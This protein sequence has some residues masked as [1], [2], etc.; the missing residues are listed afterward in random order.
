MPICP[1]CAYP[2]ADGVVRCPECGTAIE[3]AA[4]PGLSS[5]GAQRTP[6]RARPVPGLAVSKPTSPTSFVFP[7]KCCSCRFPATVTRPITASGRKDASTLIE[8]TVE[9]PLCQRCADKW[10][11]AETKDV[12]VGAVIGAVL[13]GLARA[14][15]GARLGGVVATAA[16]LG[17]IGGGVGLVWGHRTGAPAELIGAHLCPSAGRDSGW[18]VHFRNPAYQSD[19]DEVNRVNRPPD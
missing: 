1:N 18:Y 16:V 12:I 15:E 11:H 2:V 6:A 13:G 5:S 10:A 8:V 4:A 14:A 7:K 17:V 9:V 3:P 19:F